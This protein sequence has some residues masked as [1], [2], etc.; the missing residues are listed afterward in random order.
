MSKKKFIS[1][2]TFA[3]KKSPVYGIVVIMLFA[4]GIVLLPGEDLGELLLGGR[5]TDARNLGN[6]IFRLAGF[7]VIVAL[8]LNMGLDVFSFNGRWRGVLLALP[9]IAV[10]IN[11]APIIGLICGDVTVNVRADSFI[12]FALNCSAVGL[13]EETVFRG[14][15]FPLVLSK[16]ESG[17]KG[18]FWSVV[19][20]SALFGAVH[21]VNLFGSAPLPVILQVGYSFLIGAMCAVVMLLCRNIFVTA[22]IHAGFNF[23]GLMADNLGSGM[24]WTAFPVMLTVIIGAL[25]VG[26]AVWLFVKIISAD[27]IKMFKENNTNCNNENATAN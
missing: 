18:I 27:N 9:F 2:D 14:I 4:M 7:A 6:A 22:A 13:F 25:A 11:N 3:L 19:I 12:I 23:C 21:L 8:A 5:G 1:A 16:A 15:I 26:Y 24:V 10:V 17:K 20:S